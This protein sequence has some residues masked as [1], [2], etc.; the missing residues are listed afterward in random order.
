MDY[1]EI[2]STSLESVK[3]FEKA[4]ATALAKHFKTCGTAINELLARIESMEAEKQKLCE[5]ADHLK[6]LLKSR[7]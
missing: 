1:K 3:I 5:E 7:N 6:D 2:A 4:R